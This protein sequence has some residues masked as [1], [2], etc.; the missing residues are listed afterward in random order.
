MFEPIVRV[1]KAYQVKS[2]FRM[3]GSGGMVSHWKFSKQEAIRDTPGKLAPPILGPT[4]VSRFASDLGS[5]SA[6]GMGEAT[7]IW[8]NKAQ[9]AAMN[10]RI[11][12]MTV[13]NLNQPLAMQLIVQFR[14]SSQRTNVRLEKIV[15]STVD[16]RSDDRVLGY[17][18]ARPESS[19][20]CVRIIKCN[21]FSRY[22]PT[23]GSRGVSPAWHSWASGRL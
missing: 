7:H 8:N 9:K 5:I 20:F 10:E 16:L 19:R 23:G 12:D 21:F 22:R 1:A 3:H 4:I 2:T 15:V 13:Q 11:R 18:G 6:P 14:N 17:G